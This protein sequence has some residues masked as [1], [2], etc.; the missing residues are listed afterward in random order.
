MCSPRLPLRRIAIGLVTTVIAAAGA[1][2][3]AQ[4]AAGPLGV[5]EATARRLIDDAVRA[6]P[7]S[8]NSTA[9]FVVAVRRAYERLPAPGRATAVTAAFAWASAYVTSPAF[10]KT[11]A[12]IRQAHKPAAAAVY[13]QSV[14]AELQQRIDKERADL[15]ESKK[16]IAVLP[17]ADRPAVLAAFKEAEER[18]GGPE[19]RKAWRDEIESRLN[20]DAAGTAAAVD[21]WNGIYPADPRVFVRKELQRFLEATAGVDFSTPITVVRSLD[22][23]IVGFV[24]PVEMSPAASP[25]VGWASTECLLAGPEAV[26]A[27]R[28][29]A[30]AMVKELAR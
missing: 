14:E 2:G 9:A 15:E 16:A 28:A 8:L 3:I 11:Y 21:D 7:R 27:A 24:A 10:A 23:V 4:T 20:Q 17:E 1:R 29:A 30:E 19:L 12:T 5:S 22:G 6:N 26:A 18:L 25:L 13:D